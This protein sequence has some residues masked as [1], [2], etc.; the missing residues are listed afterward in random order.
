[1]AKL[2]SLLGSFSQ[3]CVLYVGD[4]KWDPN[5]E[6]YTYSNLYTQ[7]IISPRP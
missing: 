6:N 7:I 3:A 5:I 1:M 4:L 2:L